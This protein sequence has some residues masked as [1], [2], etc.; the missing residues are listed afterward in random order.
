MISRKDTYLKEKRKKIKRKLVGTVFLIGIVGGSYS[1]AFAEADIGTLLS[2]WFE[3]QKIESI[4]KIESAINQER[5]IQTN[6]LKQELQLEITRADQALDEFTDAEIQLRIK[7]LQ[8]Y[9]DELIKS[10]KID[11]TKERE[12]IIDQINKIYNR[13][14]EQLSKVKVDGNGNPNNGDDKIKD[15]ENPVEKEKP[16]MDKVVPEKTDNPIEKPISSIPIKPDDRIQSNDPL[17]EQVPNNSVE[18][19]VITTPENPSS[20]SSDQS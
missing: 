12:R 11:D 3:K 16:Q 17:T 14:V 7:N 8:A 20:E 4:E 10:I 2:Q 6:R 5:D 13:A 1:V 19:P 18:K 9:T 15:L